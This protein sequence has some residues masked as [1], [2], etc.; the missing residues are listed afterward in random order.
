[1]RRII[2]DVGAKHGFS[3]EQMVGPSTRHALARA[4]WEAFDRLRREIRIQ[5][6]PPSL[7]LVGGWFGRDHT[8]VI[9]GLQ[10]LAQGACAA[11]PT[12]RLQLA[13]DIAER[14]GL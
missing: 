4:R 3:V 11:S 6:N 12:V 14:S 1:V 5:G 7:P 13:A 8:T 9:H 10:R 2:T